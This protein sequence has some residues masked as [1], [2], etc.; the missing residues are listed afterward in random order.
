MISIIASNIFFKKLENIMFLI[1][2]IGYS[3][4]LNTGL[5]VEAQLASGPCPDS[6]AQPEAAKAVL[7]TM[8]GEHIA[9][10][11]LVAHV[12]ACV[13]PPPVSQASPAPPTSSTARGQS[14]SSSSGIGTSTPTCVLFPSPVKWNAHARSLLAHSDSGKETAASVVKRTLTMSHVARM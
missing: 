3:W 1:E 10:I 2:K 6:G 13:H 8:P 7:P 5:D 4:V 9:D 11:S 12:L 14:M